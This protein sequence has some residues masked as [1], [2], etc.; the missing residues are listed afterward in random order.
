M[1]VCFN[2]I[3]FLYSW[4]LIVKERNYLL[5]SVPTRG[6]GIVLLIFWTLAFVTE[7]LVFI[8][9]KHAD[10]WFNLTTL[11]DKVEMGLFVSRYITTLLIF[12]IGLKAPGMAFPTNDYQNLNRENQENVSTWGDSIRKLRTLFPFLWP[13]KDLFLQFRVL[14]CFV[15]L[16]GGRVINVYVPIYNKKIVDSLTGDN[17]LFRWDWILLYVGMKFLQGGGTGS[18][19]VLN[20]LRSFLWIRI[21]QYTTREIELE[22]FAHLHSL[23]L[24]WHLN[25]KTG[26]VLRIM[27]RGTDS[28]TNLLNYILFSIA[29]TIIDI[30]VAVVFFVTAF[31]IW[32]GIIVFITMVLYIGKQT[33]KK[34]FFFNFLYIFVFQWQQSV[35]Q[36]GVQS[37]NDA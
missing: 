6:H 11:K 36:N 30:L 3:G 23:S 26:E 7:N 15:L 18:M 1:S 21:Q 12:V 33:F 22:L 25:R 10:W 9:Y 28:I 32:F 17:I 16:L 31:N 13:K 35:S 8:N 37:F 2:V 14:F 27:D 19:G 34:T 5:P 24:R 20:N 4:C 29:P